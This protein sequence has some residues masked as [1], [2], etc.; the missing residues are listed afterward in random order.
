M[1]DEIFKN[2]RIFDFRNENWMRHNFLIY[3]TL[4]KNCYI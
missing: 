4:T 3:A 1:N 2:G